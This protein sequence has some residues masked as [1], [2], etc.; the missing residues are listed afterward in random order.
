MKKTRHWDR[1]LLKAHLATQAY[2]QDHHLFYSQALTLQQLALLSQKSVATLQRLPAF[3]T[4]MLKQPATA[5]LSETL[6]QEMCLELNW[7][8][9]A[10]KTISPLA[11]AQNHL[12]PQHTH[13]WNRRA[14]IVT[15]MGHVNHGKTT[16][17]DTLRRSRLVQQEV[18]QITQKMGAYQV[19]WKQQPITFIDT[20]GHELFSLMRA[21][22][23]QITDLVVLVVAANEGVQAQTIEALQH[24][25][26]SQA[27]LIV[28]LNKTD[29]PNLQISTIQE[30][31]TKYNLTPTEWGGQTIYVQ[32]SARRLSTLDPLLTA[33]LEQAT[34]RKL[35]YCSL[36]W[37]QAVVLEAHHDR[38]G[39]QHDIIVQKGGFRTGQFLATT[40]LSGKLRL[41]RTDQGTTANQIHAGQ[42]AAFFGLTGNLPTS[43]MIYAFPD[44]DMVQF[45]KSLQ[46][47]SHHA[48]SP[49]SAMNTVV[50]PS[51]EQF[52][53]P[54][55]AANTLQ[56]VLIKVD[57]KGTEA[58]LGSL[59]TRLSDT[60]AHLKLVRL[61]TGPL[62]INDY[63]LALA[64][65]A[66]VLLFGVSGA[67]DLLSSL[68]NHQLSY[69]HFHLL[70]EL[71]LTL[72]NLA[73]L[74]TTT[75]MVTV[76]VGRAAIIRTFV[77][78][79][80][81]TIAGC[82]I[83]KG[84]ISMSSKL[85]FKHYRDQKLL[86]DKLQIKSLEQEKMPIKKAR[87]NQEV[88]MIFKKYNDLKVGDELVQFELVAQNVS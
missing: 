32:G 88:G 66:T 68:K 4:Q 44:R 76:E 8:F 62:T 24:A 29:L 86:A 33:I 48:P 6:L 20:P 1:K 39:A 81:G 10:C 22:G 7:D 42:A 19:V 73:Q 54:T 47:T 67:K 36:C 14:P 41:I 83:T 5:K 23:T 80:I 15:V 43:Q 74:P 87:A 27:P 3:Q 46:T 18:G 28:F 25:Q 52:W 17:L 82:T 65:R 77:H 78:S 64:S 50:S 40:T 56:H 58:V 30:K 57:T 21:R 34:T 13:Q 51:S 61:A 55:S 37:G 11:I 53:Q 85:W 59:V 2:C 75:K 45:L 70:H 72:E 12:Q 71:L 9:T 31:L 26:N 35:T 79:K 84:Q 69:Q 16:L 38:Q 63:H 60:N 49:T